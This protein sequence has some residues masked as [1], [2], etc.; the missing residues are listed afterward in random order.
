MFHFCSGEGATSA[1]RRYTVGPMLRISLP[2]GVGLE[3]DG[4]Y[5]RLGYDSI[6][7]T[8][9]MAYYTRVIENSWE[10]PVLGTFHFLRR[11]PLKPYI[12]GGPSFR[13]ASTSAISANRSY[14]GGGGP[15]SDPAN[16]PF[17]LLAHRS[18]AGAA[19]G[20][21]GEVHAGPL[22]ISPELRYSRWMAD[23]PQ[24]PSLHGNQN[25]LELLVGFSVRVR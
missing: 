1:T 3:F 15:V 4:L 10:F 22:R 7:E 23:V 19:V 14:P 8:A 21:G 13:M 18:E 17:V 20:V 24:D 9:C 16:N 25:Q 12:S 6:S 5:K 2:H 11:L